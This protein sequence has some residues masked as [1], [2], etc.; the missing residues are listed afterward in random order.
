M[1]N[2]QMIEVKND[3]TSA[4]SNA[5]DAFN[6]ASDARHRSDE[7]MKNITDLSD[8]ISSLL[9]QTENND[10]P[11]PSQVRTLAQQVLEKNIPLKP[12]E[13]TE[14]ADKIKHIV[15]SLTNP[16]KILE[17]TRYDLERATILAARAEHAKNAALEKQNLAS[18]VSDLLNEAKEAQDLAES[19]IT[20]ANE[21]IT[22]SE[23]DLTEIIEVTRDAKKKADNTSKS[24]DSLEERLKKLQTHVGKNEF[25]VKQ[26]ISH[27]GARVAEDAKIVENKTNQLGRQYKEA[28][29]LLNDRVDKSKE[30]I[31]RAK[32]LLQ[33]ASELTAD[34]SAKFKDLD[35]MESVYKD[36]ERILSGLMADVDALTEEMTRQLESIELKSQE[37]RQCST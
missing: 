5:Q 29:D 30:N 7:L 9:D 34:T 1:V 32:R 18:K 16:D 6:F 20:K 12:E 26:E 36:N 11:T 19:A 3:A 28:S 24:V 17:E 23:K 8:K 14:L 15:S 27:E 22:L 31:Q 35:G 13:I 21:D 37:Y 10:H 4:R 33:Q 2:F 25:I